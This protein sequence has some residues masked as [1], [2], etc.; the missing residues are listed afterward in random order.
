MWHGRRVRSPVGAN[1]LRQALW[2]A[3]AD[4]RRGRG[5]AAP[6]FRSGGLRGRRRG[7][8]LG[9]R[10]D[11]RRRRRP[12]EDPGQLDALG[13]APGR[14]R[15][16]EHHEYRRHHPGAPVRG[17]DHLQRGCPG[18]HH[19]GQPA[20]RG[21][22]AQHHRRWSPEPVRRDPDLPHSMGRLSSGRQ[23]QHPLRRL[24]RLLQ[25]RQRP[26]RQRR[27]RLPAE[28]EHA[29]PR[30]LVRGLGRDRAR[31]QQH[32]GL[33]AALLPGP[34]D[35][36]DLQDRRHGAGLFPGP[37]DGG[38]RHPHGLGPVRCLFP[39]QFDRRRRHDPDNLQQRRGGD[40]Q[41]R[42]RKRALHHQRRR[43]ARLRP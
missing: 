16:P 20:D 29:V 21:R 15:L 11:R 1:P 4:R 8:P 2:P 18:L 13:S 38:E 34:V 25:Q 36:R 28:R 24:G 31:Y 26:D 10:L 7:D 32:H 42:H 6:R 30:H 12:L 3:A 5:R 40:R 22:A 33:W 37:L 39:G 9:Q 35:R 14:G 17:L 43:P 23:R 41:R 19:P 27:R